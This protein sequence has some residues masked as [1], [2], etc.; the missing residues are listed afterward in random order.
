VAMSDEPFPQ[1]GRMQVG[2]VVK[3]LAA[4]TEF[5]S[6]IL[7]LP[8]LDDQPIPGGMLRRFLLG[9][10]GL[11]LVSFDRDP[12]SANP[13]DGMAAGATGLRYLTIDVGDVAGTVERCTAAGH[14]VPVPLMEF[15]PGMPIA[16]V[17][18]PEGNW[19]ELIQ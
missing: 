3:D 17:A 10:A 1:G 14:P 19:I 12:T 5:Y 15:R 2:I 4:M 18:D 9:D 8:H 16:I 6:V 11:K 13:P 7:G